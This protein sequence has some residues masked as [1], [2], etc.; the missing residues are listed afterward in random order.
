MTSHPNDET[1]DAIRTVSRRVVQVL[2]F[3]GSDFA[4]TDLSPS[5]VHALI[6]IDAADITAR[7][8]SETLNLEKSS[9]S[10][11][12]GKLVAKGDVAERKGRDGR[13][14]VL[15]LTAAGKARVAEIHA[16]A[17]RQVSGALERLEND[18]AQTVFDG[19]HLYAGA[20][21][22]Q[23]AT[24]IQR[25]TT[26]IETGYTAGLIA[27]S[28][29]LHVHFYSRH[30]GFGQV[31]EAVV[32][33]GLAEFCGRLESPHNSIWVARSE[34]AI[35]GSITI[36]GED[37]GDGVAHL[38]WFIL[39]DE[40][41][42]AGLGRTLLRRA[43]NFVDERGF[44]ETHLWTFDGLKAA[45]HLYQ[46]HGFMLAEERP[47]TQWGDEVMEQRFVRKARFSR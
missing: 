2:G 35:V 6:E 27:R 40:A 17:R 37:L 20:L 30:V 8:L 38:R 11:M 1:I 7:D 21:G 36:D 10:R 33:Q 28:T 24:D 13:V 19:L 23:A 34:G 44:D 42:G 25:A 32:A 14:R 3:T 4:G 15:S 43:L 9:V 29:A 22:R 41:R 5:A 26:T 12:I 16:F 39:G 46:T 47:G 45:R 18:E 31:F